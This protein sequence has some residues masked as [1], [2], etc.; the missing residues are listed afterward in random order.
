MIA[1][2]TP[3]VPGDES[4]SAGPEIDSGFLKSSAPDHLE[5][6]QPFCYSAKSSE[7][8]VRLWLAFP[9][10]LCSKMKVFGF[11][12]LQVRS[13]KRQNK[14][15]LVTFSSPRHNTG[16]QVP[17][18]DVYFGSQVVDG[19]SIICWLQGREELLMA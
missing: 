11:S 16:H 8:S 1:Q 18:G 10:W 15:M 5:M 6:C 3:S 12:R 19:R 9:P 14:I 13:E 17:K 2:P 4:Y 7:A